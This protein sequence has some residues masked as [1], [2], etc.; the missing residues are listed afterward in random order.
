[1]AL[2]REQFKQIIQYLKSIK[3]S[4]I[5]TKVATSS[6]TVI[7]GVANTQEVYTLTDTDVLVIPS[8]SITYLTI[9]LVGGTTADIAI[10]GGNTI[11]LNGNDINSL[12]VDYTKYENS[13]NPSSISITVAGIKCLVEFGKKV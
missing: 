11:Q 12:E 5:S 4:L 7:E 1:M 8:G 10:T 6:A 3:L 13:L 9:A 2:E